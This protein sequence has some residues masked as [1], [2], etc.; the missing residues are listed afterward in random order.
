MSIFLV[1]SCKRSLRRYFAK[2]RC[3]SKFRNIHKK[4]PVLESL[5]NKVAKFWFRF[6]KKIISMKT[7]TSRIL[8]NQ[9]SNLMT[10]HDFRQIKK[11]CQLRCFILCLGPWIRLQLNCLIFWRGA[12]NI[13]MFNG[14]AEFL[15][16]VTFTLHLKAQ[17][18]I[19]DILQGLSSLR[20]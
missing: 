2:K 16:Y 3:S 19:W 1:Y 14:V 18:Q 4:T 13:K 6:S 5:S 20:V 12:T 11:L 9:I 17:W 7:F 10:S 8:K 15:S